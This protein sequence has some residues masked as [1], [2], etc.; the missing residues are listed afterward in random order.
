MVWK[1]NAVL[2]MTN[3]L[4]RCA[5]FTWTGEQLFFSG[6]LASKG[7]NASV[8]NVNHAGEGFLQ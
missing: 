7:K 3:S 2:R 8:F 6:L 1:V 5:P 4:K